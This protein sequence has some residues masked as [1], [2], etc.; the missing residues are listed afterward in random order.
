METL[1]SVRTPDTNKSL[2]IEIECV[3]PTDYLMYRHVGFFYAGDDGSIRVPWHER[4]M[5]CEYVSQPLPAAWL[6]K[7]I[8]KL[9]RKYPWEENESCGV[10]VHV[11]RKW[12]SESK[13]KSILAF[14]CTLSE[15]DRMRLFGRSS[16]H[17]CEAGAWKQ[18]GRYTAINAE[19]KHTFEFRVFSS[20]NAAWCKY[21][22]DMVEY[23]I[24]QAYI[25]N[26]DAI[27]AFRDQYKNI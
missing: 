19:N 1:P 20:G 10:H 2:G 9:Y 18:H 15:G 14:M 4:K 5:G 25:L 3:I 17:F 21:C 8:D 6:K 26:I 27:H 12:L 16:N 23:L 22:V 13:A 24:K 11:S 7:E